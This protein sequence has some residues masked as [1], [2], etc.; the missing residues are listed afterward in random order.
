MKVVVARHMGMCFGV[1]DALSVAFA[2]PDPRAVTIYGELVHNEEVV[3]E[4]D[5]RGFRRLSESERNP[6]GSTLPAGSQRGR[7]RPVPETATALI[8]AHGISDRERDRLEAAGKSL[9]DTTCPLVRSVHE[10]AARMRAEGRFIVVIGKADHVEVRGLVGDFEPD[11]CVVVE[12]ER[13]VR[14]WPSG[15]IGVVCQTTAAAADV[16]KIHRRILAMNGA[17]DVRFVNTICRPTRLRQLAVEEL[18][19]R[20]DALVVVGGKRS[21]NTRKLAERAAERGI[22]CQVVQTA[23]DLDA[24][25]CA[26]FETVGLTAG[27]STPPA[28]VAA[29]I[30]ALHEIRDGCGSARQAC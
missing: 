19:H 2:V 21:N 11:D 27:T 25:W 8:T 4:L 16:R 20:V 3:A 30:A 13:E 14:T 17:S 24:G 5:R 18:L 7:E 1:R 22:P 10:T 23:R 29:V 6:P 26:Q 9:I 28:T 15:R 12:H